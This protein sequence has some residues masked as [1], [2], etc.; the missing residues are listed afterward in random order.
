MALR[1]PGNARAFHLVTFLVAAGA[2]V[3][4]LVLIVE[5]GQHLDTE[6]GVATADD[7]DLG[8]R[9]VRFV[10]Y[11]TILFNVLVAATSAVLAADPQRSG[12][13]VFRALRLD[14]LILAVG[15]GV[16]HWF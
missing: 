12:G 5:G 1:S 15:G 2:V 7:P 4:Q 11:L 9:L 3:L 13:P 10:S 8:T 16:V 14:A 6:P